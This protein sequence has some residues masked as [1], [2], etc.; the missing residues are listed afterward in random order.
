[1]KVAGSFK[2]RNGLRGSWQLAGGR[3]KGERRESHGSSTR[4]VLLSTS[5]IYGFAEHGRDGHATLQHP[6]TDN[7]PLK[8]VH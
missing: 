5:T 1:M 2:A 6:D 7:C 3:K 4:T 8:T